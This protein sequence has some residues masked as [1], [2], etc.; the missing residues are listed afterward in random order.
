MTKVYEYGENHIN[1]KDVYTLIDCLSDLG[2]LIE[3]ITFFS[4]TIMNPI[5]YHSYLLK[6]I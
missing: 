5:S 2:G 1:I 4:F 3:I 6:A